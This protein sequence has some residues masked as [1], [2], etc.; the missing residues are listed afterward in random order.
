MT[1]W[2][3]FPVFAE[4]GRE[5]TRL[6]VIIALC[7]LPAWSLLPFGGSLS[8]NGKISRGK[9]WNVPLCGEAPPSCRVPLLCR[10]SRLFP[11]GA[12]PGECQGETIGPRKGGPAGGT[13]EN[14]QERRAEK[15]KQS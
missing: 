12:K 5:R 3:F 4:N 6:R 11:V 7:A 15:K 8:E 2:A 13:Q 10:K 1:P 9:G 14:V